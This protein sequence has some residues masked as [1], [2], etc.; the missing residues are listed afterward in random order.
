MVTIKF[1]HLKT[2]FLDDWGGGGGGGYRDNF[3]DRAKKYQ[4]LTFTALLILNF[5]KMSKFSNENARISIAYPDFF[6][7][8]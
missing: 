1:D 6:E 8:W 4:H 7:I 5:Q 3:S 2:R